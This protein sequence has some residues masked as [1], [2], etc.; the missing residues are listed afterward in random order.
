MSPGTGS[1]FAVLPPENATG[2]WV[3]VVQRLPVRLELDEHRSTTGRC[4]RASV[5]PCGSTPAIAA[6]GAIRSRPRARRRRRNERHSR[7]G[8][9]GRRPSRDHRRGTDGDLHAGG[10]HLAAQCGLALYPRHA[11]DGRRRGRLD[12]YLVYR[13]E[14]HHHADG[15]LAC[16]P[17]RPKG[18]FSDLDRHLCA[19]PCARDARRRPRCNSSPPASSKAPRAAPSLRCRWR[20]CSIYRRPHGTP[21]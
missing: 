20:S 21:A 16:G 19:R 4:S 11:V 8:R 17:L 12:I 13:G 1:D 7:A 9:R 18:R 10:H 15:A 2:N 5:S 14:R 3:K 6:P